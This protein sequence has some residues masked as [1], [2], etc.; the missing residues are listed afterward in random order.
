MSKQWT[1]GLCSCC[2]DPAACLCSW[3]IPCYV[4]GETTNKI[5]NGFPIGCLVMCFVPFL[6]PCCVTGPVRTKK[7]IE[8]NCCNDCIRCCC[9]GVCEV[10]RVYRE[11]KNDNP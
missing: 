9:C 6:Y 8:G 3:C 7:N 11:V 10:T 5:G 1:Y 2:E 4:A